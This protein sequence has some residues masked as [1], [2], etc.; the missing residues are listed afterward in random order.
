M[1]VEKRQ[2]QEQRDP[3]PF[4]LFPL[5]DAALVVQF[6]DE[7]SPEVHR[8]VAAFA[9]YLNSQSFP[10]FIESVPAYCTLTVYY[11][12]LKVGEMENAT[13]YEQVRQYL[14][15]LAACIESGTP[16]QARLVEI[17]V[18]YGGT[19]G[20][21]LEFVAQH[22]KLTVEEVM[23][24]H[25]QK[26]Y[27][28]YMIGFAPGFPYMGGMDTRISAPR[29]ET[30]R[31]KI[32][33]GTVGIANIQTGIYSLETPGGWQLIGRTPLTLFNHEREPASLLQAGDK[34]RFV[35]VTSEEY[36][37]RKAGQYEF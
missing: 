34:V 6:G 30:P 27:L 21:D 26:E 22:N 15:R 35:P 24:I 36:W 10:G 13:P 12:P 28:V 19:F 33:A 5:G 11:D 18:C 4:K 37:E 17:P 20:P 8:M 14:Y 23:A 16:Q 1:Q 9:Q 29:K 31:S 25:S 3:Y 7:I 2:K 32:P